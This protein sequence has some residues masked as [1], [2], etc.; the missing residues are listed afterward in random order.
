MTTIIA[1]TLTTTTI[2]TLITKIITVIITTKTLI[3]VVKIDYQ[4]S[5]CM[6]K[7]AYKV[8][9]VFSYECKFAIVDN[10]TCIVYTSKELY[11][12][13]GMEIFAKE[14]KVGKSLRELKSTPMRCQ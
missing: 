13:T 3:T 12:L 1:M 14:P 8:G 7:N 11:F 4:F 10:S 9:V 2:I 5:V 6:K